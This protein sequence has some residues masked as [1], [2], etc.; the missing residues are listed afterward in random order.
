[1]TSGILAAF[2]VKLGGWIQ[3]GIFRGVSGS[4]GNVLKHGSQYP[5]WVVHNHL[6]LVGPTPQVTMGTALT[7]THN[8]THTHT[9]KFF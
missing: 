2:A 1:M 8:P 9:K 6:K 4:L 7:C 5:G 3:R